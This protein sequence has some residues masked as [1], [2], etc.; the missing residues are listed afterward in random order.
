MEYLIIV[1]L[2]LINEGKISEIDC[3]DIIIAI[4]R[5]QTVA[6]GLNSP[7]EPISEETI[8]KLLKDNL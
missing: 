6:L 1:L 5:D 8:N 2:R 7:I 4:M 3:S